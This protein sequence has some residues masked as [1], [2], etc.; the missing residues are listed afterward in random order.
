M[1]NWGMTL[2]DKLVF[3]IVQLLAEKFLLQFVFLLEAVHVQRLH[4][5]RQAA[6]LTLRQALLGGAA[7]FPG[8]FVMTGFCVLNVSKLIWLANF[9][10]QIILGTLIRTRTLR[11]PLHFM[12]L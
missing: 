3:Q 4:I 6:R 11:Q 7:A 10:V 1:A 8:S 2:K 9:V 12:S 5:L